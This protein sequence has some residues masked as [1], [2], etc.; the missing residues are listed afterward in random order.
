MQG[1][2]TLKNKGRCVSELGLEIEGEVVRSWSEETERMGGRNAGETRVEEL[3]GRMT[4]IT[5]T[6]SRL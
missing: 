1:E 6:P 4:I 2:F 3:K 5:S